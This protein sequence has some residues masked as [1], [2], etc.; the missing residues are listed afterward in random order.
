M[1]TQLEA[2]EKINLTRFFELVSDVFHPITNAGLAFF[3]LTIFGG[4]NS[5]AIKIFHFSIAL[6]FSM[7]IPFLYVYYLKKRGYLK[8]I[9]I[10]ERMQR[11]N[12]FAFSILSYFA[13][14]FAL[15]FFDASLH[16]QGLM[17][18]YGSNT[19]LVML[20]TKWWKVSVHTTGIA[21]P[22]V[23]LTFEYGP[24]VFPFYLLIIIVG[25]SRVYLKRHTVMQVLVGGAMGL[26]LTY[27][28]FE[29]FF[30]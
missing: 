21:G 22:L 9:D 24:I 5:I 20:V 19:L 10:T 4:G 11:L 25:W 26:L 15:L 14:F 18:C 16:V 12:P 7:I 28:Q 17:F 23:A 29:I 27:L 13:G 6:L 3:L 8:T 2:M 30:S 1:N